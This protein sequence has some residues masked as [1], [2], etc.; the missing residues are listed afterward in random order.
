MI[1][2]FSDLSNTDLKIIKIFYFCQHSKKAKC[3]N[4]FTS[5]KQFLKRPNGNTD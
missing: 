3:P 4:H 1:K 5:G 2:I